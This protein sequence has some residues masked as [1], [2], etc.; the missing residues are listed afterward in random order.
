VYNI[1][2]YLSHIVD[3]TTS[4]RIVFTPV[5]AKPYAS[6]KRNTRSMKQPGQLTATDPFTDRSVAQNSRTAGVSFPAHAVATVPP[7][8]SK[9]TDAATA[10][11]SVESAVAHHEFPIQCVKLQ[12]QKQDSDELQEFDVSDNQVM[13]VLY[14]TFHDYALQDYPQDS[15]I[16]SLSNEGRTN[17]SKN[18]ELGEQRVLGAHP[19][20]DLWQVAIDY[21]KHRD[22][23]MLDVQS[24]DGES[25]S[26]TVYN[27]YGKTQPGWHL[28]DVM[29]YKVPEKK[30]KK[31]ESDKG[32]SYGLAAAKFKELRTALECSDAQIAQAILQF[33]KDGE[34]PKVVE[35]KK[36][37]ANFGYLVTLM[38]VPESQRSIGTFSFGLI[39]LDNIGKGS[40]TADEAF[41]AAPGK[42]EEIEERETARKSNK[43]KSAN[44]KKNKK[45]KDY[46]EEILDEVVPKYYDD[47]DLGGE[48]APAF[49]GSKSTLNTME[50]EVESGKELKPVNKPGNKDD[51]FWNK[52]LERYETMIATFLSNHPELCKIAK[53][54]GSEEEALEELVRNVNAH[55]GIG[56]EITGKSTTNR[57]IN[58]SKN[59]LLENLNSSIRSESKG[60]SFKT[61]LLFP[62]FGEM[63]KTSSNLTGKLVSEEELGFGSKV[64][65]G[66]SNSFLS[67]DN[68]VSKY[69]ITPGS[70]T[71]NFG[72]ELKEHS[73]RYF[74]SRD[75]RKEEEKNSNSQH[76]KR[77]GEHEVEDQQIQQERKMIFRKENMKLLEAADTLHTLIRVCLKKFTEEQE[78]S[79][80]DV[81]EAVCATDQFKN[82]VG[83]VLD[84]ESI[85]KIFSSTL[86]FF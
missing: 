54:V 21:K 60:G 36:M 57:K 45:T 26:S 70:P 61:D 22:T 1:H 31:D 19:I 38:T 8:G 53:V 48:Y 51:I 9:Q 56:E 44:N 39:M 73:T 68:S 55:F 4:T 46:E 64:F 83:P 13:N 65:G 37:L 42:E 76:L 11:R 14:K 6:F 30:E 85:T 72:D 67:I 71:L 3:A 77:K 84:T 7:Q 43:T 5:T 35:E 58:R 18:T 69:P 49:S 17:L 24:K 41:K 27:Q 75:L 10:G 33:Y 66:F 40:T 34:V 2:Y 23:G 29:I 25:L 52:T 63:L 74:T 86:D 16:E 80:N 28:S 47:V 81:I 79:R 15:R 78:F 50:T 20:D 62:D 82:E 32:V 59:I 12:A